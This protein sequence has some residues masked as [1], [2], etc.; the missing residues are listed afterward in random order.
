MNF[1]L[2]PGR[3]LASSK[4]LRRRA[5]GVKRKRNF[6]FRVRFVM[7]KNAILDYTNPAPKVSHY[8]RNAINAAISG[9]LFLGDWWT[10]N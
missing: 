2:T 8:R 1:V 5:A 4:R 7:G 10:G 6:V 3:M 9:N